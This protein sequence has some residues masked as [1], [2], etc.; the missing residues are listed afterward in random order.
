MSETQI[1]SSGC[2]GDL[3]DVELVDVGGGTVIVQPV[4]EIDLLS[5]PLLAG[6]LT[7]QVVGHTRV[8]VDMH[9]VAFFGAS[10]LRALVAG[11]TAA[12]ARGVGFVVVGLDDL[13]RRVLRVGG[14]EQLLPIVELDPEEMVRRL[15][16]TEPTSTVGTT[17]DG[18]P[19]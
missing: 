7:E 3:L 5:A 14:G 12:Q 6:R 11:H 19:G 1:P 16:R 4:G 13:M 15:G 18:P 2:P 10:G 8:V 17:P 9:R